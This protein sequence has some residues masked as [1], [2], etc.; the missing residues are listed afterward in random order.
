MWS[1]VVSPEPTV[2][3]TLADT[4]WLRHVT[5][6]R[7][8]APTCPNANFFFCIAQ[9]ALRESGH[10]RQFD[11]NIIGYSSKDEKTS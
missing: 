9:K 1:D 11:S 3:H 7:D 5:H 10:N 6:R 2:V 8:A 4:I